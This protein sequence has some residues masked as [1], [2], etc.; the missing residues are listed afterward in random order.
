MFDLTLPSV[1]L[2]P[3][4]VGGLLTDRGVTV[5]LTEVEAYAGSEDPAAHAWAGPRPR[6]K[7]LFGPPGTLYCY[8][9]HGL[10]ICGNVVCGVPGRGSAVLFRAGRVVAGME[11]VRERRPGVADA[12]LARGPGNLGRALGW[13]LADSGRMFAADGPTLEPGEPSRPVSSGPRVGVSVAHG[14]PWR[15][16][17]DGDPTVSGY[18]RSP[19]IV[20]GRHDW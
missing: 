18:R 10:H 16:W 1:D 9:S 4:L 5:Q 12:A 20:P 15:F 13:T 6:T 7:D 19:R 11:L 8:L 2:A 17:A 14:R 3:L